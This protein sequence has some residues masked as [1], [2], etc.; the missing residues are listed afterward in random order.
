MANG[1][2]DKVK[3]QIMQALSHPEADEGLYF[4]NL[5]HLH[6]ADERPAVE[7]APEAILKALEELI[8]EG[9]VQQDTSGEEP[10]FVI[11]R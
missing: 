8:S 10:I 3:D 7:A 4:R 1:S 2:T 11:V 5:Y 9:H 6:E